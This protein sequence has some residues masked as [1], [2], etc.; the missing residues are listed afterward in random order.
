MRFLRWFAFAALVLSAGAALGK[1]EK[2]Q[3]DALLSFVVGDYVIVGREPDGGAPYAGT[4]RIEPRTGGLL[5]NRRR[6]STRS[7]PLV[8]WRCLHLPT[9][10]AFCASD[11]TTPSPC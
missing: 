11:G 6:D 3:A 1:D 4:A 10:G 9:R 5:L 2:T 8:A 7:Q